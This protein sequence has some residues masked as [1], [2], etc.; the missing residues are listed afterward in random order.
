MKRGVFSILFVAMLNS[1]LPAQQSTLVVTTSQPPAVM[2]SFNARQAGIWD[3][4]FRT[5][6]ID[7]DLDGYYEPPN[8]YRYMYSTYPFTVPY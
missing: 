2:V 5:Y 1:S 4:P 3:Y 8:P 6:G 7:Y